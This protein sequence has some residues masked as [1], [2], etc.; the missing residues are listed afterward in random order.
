MSLHPFFFL[1]ST[2]NRFSSKL[3]SQKKHKDLFECAKK[4]KNGLVVKDL[5]GVV[6]VVGSVPLSPLQN[7]C[8]FLAIHID[9]A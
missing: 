1:M 9:S 4:M 5:V 2:D 8:I 7:L 3:V 6:E